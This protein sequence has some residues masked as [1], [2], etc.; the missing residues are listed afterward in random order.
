[1]N[2]GC[3]PVTGK[4]DQRWVTV[5]G[6]RRD[7]EKKLAELLHRKYIENPASAGDVTLGEFINRWLSEYAEPSLSATTSMHYHSK[8]RCHIIPRLGSLPLS[9]L[10]PPV[11]QRHYAFLVA[12]GRVMDGGPLSHSSVRHTHVILSNVLEHALKWGY[13]Y[14]NPAKA[15]RPPRVERKEMRVWDN[16]QVIQFF[17]E[18]REHPDFSIYF[19]L[20]YVDFF[21]GLRLSEILALK[22]GDVDLDSG[23]VGIRR[24]V[25]Q[26][27]N[28]SIVYQSPKSIRS[29]RT[30]VLPGSAVEVLK[31]HYQAHAGYR[32]ILGTTLKD[33]DFIFAGPDGR[34]FKPATISQAFRRMVRISGLPKIRFH[35]IRHTHASLLIKQGVNPKIIQERLGHASIQTTFDV[36]GH[37]YPGMQQVVAD[38]FDKEF[39]EGKLP[40]RLESG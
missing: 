34:P 11:L 38:V 40:E 31:R 32:T 35:D 4:R 6:S 16:I 7:A 22:W 23:E 9:K 28:G 30:I 19:Q 13:L 24:T 25:H 12:A 2:Y 39:F 1:M 15:V 14:R 3:N 17:K 18:V 33:S 5:R 37:L 21:S 26:L 8:L 10:T 29:R 36:Y 20:F 27:H